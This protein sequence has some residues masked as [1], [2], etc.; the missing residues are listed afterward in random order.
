M[1]TRWPSIALATLCLLAVTTSASAE[2]A[3][4]LWEGFSLNSQPTWNIYGSALARREE[5]LAYQRDA[6]NS[7]MTAQ[8][9]LLVGLEGWKIERRDPDTVKISGPQS[10]TLWQYKCLP[11]TLD[12]HGPK[13]K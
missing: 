10:I 12:P 3:W 11:D 13:G 5:C 4:V 1:M 7:K 8:E 9:K 2:C 6:L